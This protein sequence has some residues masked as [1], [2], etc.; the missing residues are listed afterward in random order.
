MTYR[1]RP[2]RIHRVVGP[3]ALVLIVALGAPVSQGQDAS[4]VLVIH[5]GQMLDVNTGQLVEDVRIVGAAA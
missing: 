4:D 2:G 3:V 1:L 5:A